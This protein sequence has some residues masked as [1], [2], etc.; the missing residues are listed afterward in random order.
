MSFTL[1]PIAKTAERLLL[2]IEQAVAGFPRKHRYTA[3]EELRKQAMDVTVLV[4][5]AWRDKRNQVALIERVRWEV[6][7]L[8]IRMQLCSRLRAFASLAQFEMLARVARELGKQ[9]YG[10][11]RQML[12]SGKHP[13]GQNEHGRHADVQRAEKLSTRGTSQWE[14]YR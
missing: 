13:T 1:P 10:W 9:A 2:E 6:D 8:K 5:R 11:H 12:E 4:H 3:G 7:A 14:V